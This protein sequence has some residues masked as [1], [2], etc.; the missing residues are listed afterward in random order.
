[1]TST[2][3]VESL[4]S[5][6]NLNIVLPT[7]WHR[8]P[9][10]LSSDLGPLDELGHDEYEDAFAHH[11]Y[12]SVVKK[13]S[14]PHPSASS[15]CDKGRRFNS[16]L[17]RRHTTY[18][19]HGKPFASLPASSNLLGSYPRKAHVHSWHRHQQQHSSL[20]LLVQVGLHFNLLL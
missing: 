9:H 19:Q 12:S 13:E 2:A 3:S 20:S 15:P 14:P 18:Y 8:H 17:R 10:P 7:G 5:P 4:N 16:A 11:I 6:G 1:M